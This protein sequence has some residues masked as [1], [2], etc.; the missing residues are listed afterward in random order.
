MG[1]SSAAEL[2]LDTARLPRRAL[3]LAARSALRVSA[4]DESLVID[5][6]PAGRQRFPAARIDRIVCNPVAE[7]SGAALALCLRWGITV[8]WLDAGGNALGDCVPRVAETLPLHRVLQ[9][10]VEIGDWPA[11]YGNW[12]RCR[13]MSVLLAW[14]VERKEAGNPVETGEWAARKREW[15]YN[16]RIETDL[17]SEWGGW[18]R[19]LCV[20]RL[21]GAG[22]QTRYR[23][24]GGHALEPAED[25]AALLL[26]ELVL[27]GGAFA[28]AAAD[29]RAAALLFEAAVPARVRRLHEHLGQL[30][31]FALQAVET[32][33]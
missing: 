13:R 16:A 9:Q 18:C 33:L 23:G 21:A 17:S 11:R 4:Q 3:Y 27:Q 29:T 20:A 10:L 14:A 6:R 12:L 1:A 15:V 31:R 25:L 32:W 24:F 30:H 22:L 5:R 8:T 19:S 2:G 28:A 26:A 7:W